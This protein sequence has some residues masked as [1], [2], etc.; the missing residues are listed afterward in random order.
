MPH[1]EKIRREL[2]EDARRFYEDFLEENGADPELR[3]DTART[4]LHLAAIY[5][6]LGMGDKTESSCQRALGIFQTAGY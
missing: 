3:A 2:M 1:M 5:Q 4:E 6:S